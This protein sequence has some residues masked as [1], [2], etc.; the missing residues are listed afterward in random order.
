MEGGAPATP[1]WEAD[2]TGRPKEPTRSGVAGAPPSRGKVPLAAALFN[3]AGAGGR[4][5]AARRDPR[6]RVSPVASF[7]IAA[8]A[9]SRA[10]AKA[11]E[12]RATW[13]ARSL[14]E[15]LPPAAAQA[16]EWERCRVC[17]RRESCRAGCLPSFARRI[18][19]STP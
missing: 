11:W 6:R 9:F 8:T 17:A 5:R 7:R 3:R 16:W 1:E 19:L 2:L 12:M 4:L 18:V 14:S 15:F 10:W 13:A